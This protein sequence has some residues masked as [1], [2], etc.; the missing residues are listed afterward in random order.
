MRV[1]GERVVAVHRAEVEAEDDLG[2]AVARHLVA[3]ARPRRA[4]TP[5]MKSMTITRGA[6][7]VG[8]DLGNHD[9]RM[10]AVR[11]RRPPACSAPRARSRAPRGCAR[12]PR[13][14]ASWTSRFGAICLAIRSIG[15][16]F[17][18]SARTAAAIPGYW[19]LTATSRPS[20]RRRAVDLADRRRGDRLLV[21]RREDAVQALAVLALEHPPHVA[22][23]DARRR[24]AQLRERRAH[25]VAV[26]GRHG[27][28][29]DDRQHLA[30]L[31]R[32]ALHRPQHAHDLARRV[33][34]PAP[35]RVGR[36]VRRAAE[37]RRRRRRVLRRLGRREPAERG[38]APQPPAELLAVAGV[39]PA[40]LV[41][42]RAR[43]TRALRSALA[44]DL[45]AGNDVVAAVGPA[46]PGL[47]P[48]VVVVA[49]QDERRRAR[50]APC[51]ARRPRGPGRARRG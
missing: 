44:L 4:P 11:A 17:C 10:P 1:A 40:G 27:V 48:A 3:A 2:D 7:E 41:L 25:L 33:D 22:E 37:V 6:A 19:T 34:L 49:E 12:A 36:L 35:E 28:E 51:T 43:V 16:R 30:G 5:S 24:V 50:R 18:R 23:R 13:R 32:D 26:G 9:E 47:V 42:S 8:D 38:R 29:V 20:S 39:V 31:H 15:T 45:R 46:D 14:R 21:E